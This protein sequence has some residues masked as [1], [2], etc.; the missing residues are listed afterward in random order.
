M[1]NNQY[2]KRQ[3]NNPKGQKYGGQNSGNETLEKPSCTKEQLKK[4]MQ[5]GADDDMVTYTNKLAEY[6]QDLSASKIRNIYDEMKRIQM[7]GF[8]K[9]K[10]SFYML[11]PKVAYT[12]AREDQ[13]KKEKMECFKHVFDAAATYVTS[14]TEF[15]NFCNFVEA[16]VAYHK[17][18]AKRD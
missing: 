17:L 13:R 10:A 12:Y 3:G 4:W 2:T 11:R 14:K 9:S 6:I 16:I 18:H 7:L 8:D 5:T 1:Q 15:D